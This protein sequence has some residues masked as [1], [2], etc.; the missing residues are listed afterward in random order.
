MTIDTRIEEFVK[1]YMAQYQD[2]SHDWAHVDRVRRTAL[3][4]ACEESQ[5]DE[6]KKF[7]LELLELAALLHDVGDFKYCKNGETPE[8]VIRGVLNILNLDEQKINGV[9]EIVANVS[10]RHELEHGCTP[11]LVKHWNELSVVQ[12]A[13]RLDAIGA[14][15]VARCLAFSGKRNTVFYHPNEKPNVDMN[16]EFYNEQTKNNSGSARSHFYEKL[17][18]LEG[19]MKS[20]AGKKEA[21]R[22]QAFMLSFLR[23]FEQDCMISQ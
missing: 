12:D 14:I 11:E 9:L 18:K 6:S 23:E 19:M 17:L 4:L 15:G 16:A 2:C 21:Q 13:D 20:K 22:R 8:S 5:I 1:N 10:Y 7:D 3:K